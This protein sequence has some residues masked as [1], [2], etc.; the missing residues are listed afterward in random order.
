[1]PKWYFFGGG[2]FWFPTQHTLH[3]AMDGLLLLLC[4]PN[5]P[6]LHSVP[7][8]NFFKALV[9]AVDPSLSC[10]PVVTISTTCWVFFTSTQICY[11][12][13]FFENKAPL[14]HICFQLLSLFFFCSH[15]SSYT[16]FLH[17][18][19]CILPEAHCNWIF[20]LTISLKLLWSMS[21]TTSH[22]AKLSA[23]I[24]VSTYFYQQFLV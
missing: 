6:L 11:M 4:K 2:I 23:Q 1:M 16:Y 8:S 5:P 19:H 22:N 15:T 20:I 18:L 7:S 13:P 17:F 21:P 9:P 3:L 12:S 14:T 24:S 10:D